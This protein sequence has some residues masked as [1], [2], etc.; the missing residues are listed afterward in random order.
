MPDIDFA[1]L[2]YLAIGVSGLAAF[3]IGAVWYTG[4]FGKAWA[5]QHGYSPE[6]LRQMQANRPMPIFFGVLLASYFAG[7]FVLAV[8]LSGHA[9]VSVRTGLVVGLLA[10]LIVAA[11]RMTAHISSPKPIGAFLI[12]SGFDLV[13]IPVMGMILASWQ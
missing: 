4:L 8:L 2:N 13:A 10:W 7:A 9:A 11:F 6:Q 5:R 12:D 3:C 1:H